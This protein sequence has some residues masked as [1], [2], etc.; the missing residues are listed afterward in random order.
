MSCPF[1]TT[2]CNSWDTEVHFALEVKRKWHT[3]TV[4]RQ[5]CHGRRGSM[6]IL[7]TQC[8]KDC[9]ANCLVT[10]CADACVQMRAR[11]SGILSL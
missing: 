4:S 3:V 5:P 8:Q 7:E 11:I 9:K 6:D 1:F 2:G 10:E